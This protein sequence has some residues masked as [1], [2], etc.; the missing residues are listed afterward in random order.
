MIESGITCGIIIYFDGSG[1]QVVCGRSARKMASR[2]GMLKRRKWLGQRV[3]I[4]VE[5][6]Q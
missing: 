3:T 6:I 1:I 4:S 2:S 5:E